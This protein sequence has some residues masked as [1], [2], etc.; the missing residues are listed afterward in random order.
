MTHLLYFVC[1]EYVNKVKDMLKEA[2]NTYPS[3]TVFTIHNQ[4][5]YVSLIEESAQ[6]SDT[7]TGFTAYSYQ[8]KLYTS[9]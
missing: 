7:I 8:I 4:W 9:T 2:L 6:H 1:Q 3:S 5:G